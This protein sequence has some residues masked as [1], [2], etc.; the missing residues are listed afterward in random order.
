M[1]EIMTNF[2]NRAS[3]AR[4]HFLKSTCLAS[5]FGGAALVFDSGLSLL[6]AATPPMQ[7]GWG[8]CAK[9]GMLYFTIDKRNQGRCAAQATHSPTGRRY[10]VTYDDSTGPGQ[11]DWR[12][13]R[14]CSVLFFNGYS[15]KGV[16]AA[17]H[18]D[19]EAAGY[20]FFLYH[21]RRASMNEEPDWHYCINC[22]ALFSANSAASVCPAANGKQHSA[23]GYR[24][25]VGQ[26]GT[27]ID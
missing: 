11:G 26:K 23:K 16:C 27:P 21:D 12:F 24:F 8:H 2:P 14:K 1:E 17:D 22:Q 4:R 15:K 6:H 13:C 3:V 19:H 5:F 7:D 18:G 20:E 10:Q 9:C 25:V